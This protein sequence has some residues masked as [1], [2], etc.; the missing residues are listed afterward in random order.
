MNGVPYQPRGPGQLVYASLA[1]LIL[2][3]T[4][5]ANPGLSV[6]AMV[7]LTLIVALLWRPGEPQILL[8]ACGMQ[9]IQASTLVLYADLLGKPIWKQSVAPE[10]D[11]ATGLTLVAVAATAIGLRLAIGAQRPVLRD[12]SITDG[13]RVARNYLYIYIVCAVIAAVLQVV[14]VGGLSQFVRAAQRLKWVPAFSLFLVALATARGRKLMWLVF[15]FEFV[16]GW[17]SFFADFKTPIYM[18]AIALLCTPRRLSASRWAMLAVGGGMALGLAV[19]WSSIKTDYRAFLNE[20]TGSQVVT[21]TK[22]Q[23][24]DELLRLLEQ[25]DQ[26]TFV[27][28]MDSMVTRISY[29]EYFGYALDYVPRV[30]P[31]EEG[32][33]LKGAVAHVLTPR[34]L[35]PDKPAIFDTEETARYTG[36]DVIGQGQTS[37]SLGY[38]AEAYIDFGP[39]LMFLPILGVAVLYG[40]MYRFFLYDRPEAPLASASIA[41]VLLFEVTKIENTFPKMLGGT[42]NQALVSFALYLLVFRR[43]DRW[44]LKGR[45]QAPPPVEEPSMLSGG[46]A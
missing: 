1:V 11:T 9:W 35:F 15:I 16:S 37:I 20:R 7:V 42:I 21:V 18:L 22:E 33:L 24:V 46:S 17:L 19:V 39:F 36:L 13:N 14:S 23:Q 26:E 8:F 40:I 45:V 34:F 25:I 27:R 44:A 10:V 4:T 6:L 12:L 41:V 32:A 30:R 43:A 38:P 29:V 3:A 2:L 28:G 31:H 5:T